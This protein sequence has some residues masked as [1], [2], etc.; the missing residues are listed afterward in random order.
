MIYATINAAGPIRQREKD[1]ERRGVTMVDGLAR[2]PTRTH[3]ACSG[4][5]YDGTYAEFEREGEEEETDG[6]S[7]ATRTKSGPHLLLTD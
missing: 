6:R 3:N 7:R 2:C 1:L 5:L 4:D